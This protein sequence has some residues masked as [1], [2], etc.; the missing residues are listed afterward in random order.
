M[1]IIFLAAILAITSTARL[2]GQ[3]P[4]KPTTSEIYHTLQ[5]LNFLGSA[6]YVAA[7]PD[8][9]NTRLISYLAN[10]VHARS[11]Y[12][13]LTRGD[14]GQNLIGP[15]IR[16][17]LGVIRTQELLA[18][19]RTDGGEQL[20]T[21]ANDFGYSKHPDET[22]AIWNKDEVLSD[23][24]RAIRKFKPDIIV[25]RFNHRNPGSTHG[26]H[27]A[28]AMLSFEAFDLASDPTKYPE[29]AIEFGLWQPKRLLFNTS[30]WFYGSKDAFKKADKS[31]LVSVETGNYYPALGHSNGEIASLSRSMHKS[32]G[33]GSTG[34]RGKQTEYLEFLKGTFP[35][36]P[37]SLFDG[38]NTTWS[39]I[40]GGVAI[41]AI[42]NPLV[43][44]F[45]FKNPSAMVPQLV[46]A[47]E[48]LK[49]SKKGHWRSIKLKE[50]EHLILASSGIF[51]EAVSTTES[52]NPG[53]NF[54]LKL[55][56]VNRSTNNVIL[57]GV[58][59]SSGKVIFSK[60]TLLKNNDKVVFETQ[61]TSKSK[62]PSAPYWLKT[63]G[64]LGM[65]NAP[66]EMIG[67][68]ET[69][70]P[71]QVVF[72]L[73]IGN[74]SIKII[75]DVV[76][77]FNDPV[78][79]EVYRPFQVLPEA[80]AS[81]AKK[82]LIFADQ[83]PQKV[84]VTV[85][86]GRDTL[87]GTLQLNAPKGWDVSS[88]QIFNLERQG[89]TTTLFFEVSPPKDQSEGYLRPLI[90]IGDRYYDKELIQIEYDHIPYQSVLLPSEA[91]V[92]RIDIKK[93]GQYIGYI[94]GA[95]DAIP[96]SLEQIGYKVNMLD[97]A[98]ISAENLKQ[99]DAVVVGIRAYNTIPALAFAQKE[100]NK[101]V[102]QGG[103]MVVQYNT[104]HRL[105]TKE[106]APFPISLSRDR[107]TDEFAAVTILDK[108]HPV[109]NSPN[110]ITSLDFENWVQE[111]GLYFPN[112][113][114]E[115]FT[116]IL[117]MNDPGADQ[118]KGSLLVASYGKGHYVYTGLSFFRE[119]PAGVPGA[120]RLF[121]NIISIG[122]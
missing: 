1:R 95:G 67:L 64:S 82:V 18:A 69:P 60:E 28:S 35:K 53:G 40:D 116:P 68:P 91:K 44:N 43:E 61:V 13:S 65:Y 107:V 106:L 6:L 30:W 21:R 57:S 59:T 15:E 32:Q 105:V 90:Q 4:E 25:N 23:V 9:E 10:D 52:I 7:H 51:L 103:T 78:A 24:V 11:A 20:F 46:A 94:Q 8:D 47:Y 70:A 42:L 85:R 104:S 76:Y 2:Y 77:K 33:F 120:Y 3:L 55:E 100:L 37:S 98:E 45:N 79:G 22:L 26:H 72:S 17:L 102:E 19:R 73:R 56:A 109:V 96:E 83:N 80:S 81:I 84:A 14:G 5:K 27:T 93:K 117:G 41:G 54:T 12:L 50:L 74:T 66:K 88:S 121:A 39:K 31:N 101:Y 97:V 110:K 16:E 111:R 29:T 86:A 34:S 38:I 122:K 92:A 89:E 75:K 48:L 113:W 119:L 36:D 108:T 115:A 62:V 118:T 63:K 112:K 49:Q 114:A 99:Y 87:E 58:T 71:E